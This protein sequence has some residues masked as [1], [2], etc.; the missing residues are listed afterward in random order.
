VAEAVIRRRRRFAAGQLAVFQ[1]GPSRTGGKASNAE[2]Q[3]TGR[4]P[5]GCVENGPAAALL[6]SYVQH[7]FDGSPR[8]PTRYLK[9][10]NWC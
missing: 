1:A 7:Q 6:I 5:D 10:S 3:P 2:K 9:T 8:K 4:G